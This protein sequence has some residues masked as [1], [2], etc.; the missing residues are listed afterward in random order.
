MITYSD[1]DTISSMLTQPTIKQLENILFQYI[2]PQEH[3]LFIF[4]S[5][6]SAKNRRY[7]DI[8]IGI[9]GIKSL[10]L[11]T[12][13]KLEDA[14]D[15]SNLPYTVDIVDFST[16]TPRFKTVAKKHIIRIGLQN[17]GKS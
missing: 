1:Y 12:L 6:T 10:P 17:N 16:V 8:D 9:E 3:S 2:D 13:S 14:F 7:S 4:G 15:N 11:E 5:R